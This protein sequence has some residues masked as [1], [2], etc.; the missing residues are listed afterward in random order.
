V[1]D[2]L[3]GSWKGKE[4]GRDVIDEIYQIVIELKETLRKIKEIKSF[5][6]ELSS[7]SS[8][9]QQ[10]IT[11]T[12]LGQTPIIQPTIPPPV[13]TTTPLQPTPTQPA[14][15]LQEQEQRK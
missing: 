11:I 3:V 15:S 7:L 8:S 12:G 4:K 10:P 6:Y 2:L 13:T 14:Q 9:S 5:F 1:N